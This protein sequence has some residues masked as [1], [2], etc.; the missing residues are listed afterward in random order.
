MSDKYEI[1]SNLSFAIFSLY[2]NYKVKR[3]Q[4]NGGLSNGLYG[5]C[6]GGSPKS[7]FQR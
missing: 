7:L 6:F 2:K 4:V 1:K 5:N 3:R